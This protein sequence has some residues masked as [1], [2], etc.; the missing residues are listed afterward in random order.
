MYTVPFRQSLNRLSTG[1]PRTLVESLQIA[2]TLSSSE[3]VRVSRE[4]RALGPLR[5]LPVALRTRRGPALRVT[6]LLASVH[7]LRCAAATE[8]RAVVLR[9]ER[10]ATFVDRFAKRISCGISLVRQTW[11]GGGGVSRGMVVSS[12]IRGPLLRRFTGI[13]EGRGNH[14]VIADS[15]SFIEQTVG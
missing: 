7:P 4:L 12:N 2:L 5:L 11:L 15:R 1:V 10:V 14:L 8:T 13:R 9:H 6:F 3:T